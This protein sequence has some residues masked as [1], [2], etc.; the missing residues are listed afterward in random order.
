MIA[1]GLVDA[2]RIEDLNTVLDD[3]EMTLAN[4][5]RIPMTSNTNIVFEVEIFVNATPATVS[6]AGIICV[7]GTDLD[8]SP[9]EEGWIE[10]SRHSSRKFSEILSLNTWV[11]VLP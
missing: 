8:W 5:D 2:I 9:V 1:D 3:N 6:G 11:K 10:S 4:D 7:S